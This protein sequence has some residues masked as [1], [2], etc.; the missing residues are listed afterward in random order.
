MS[1]SAARDSQVAR[2][3]AIVQARMGSTRLPGKVLAEVNGRSLLDHCISRLQRAAVDE[4]VLATTDLSRDEVLE[5]WAKDHGIRVFRGSEEDVLERYLGAARAFDA[6]RIVRVTSD[7]PLI[8]P[9]VVNGVL[10]LVHGPCRY[11]SNFFERR[12]FPR[13]LDVEVFTMDALETAAREDDRPGRREHV[14]PFMHTVQPDRFGAK[15]FHHE[16]DVSRHRWTVDTPED[17]ELIRRILEALPD[18]GFHWK[19]VLALMDAHPDWFDINRSI[20]QKDIPT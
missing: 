14:T 4:V 3:V 1:D 18:D 19:D 12:T 6:D 7:C 16:V 17:F 11:A 13:G 20:Q 10:A 5:A 15:G 2:T 9:D 8:D